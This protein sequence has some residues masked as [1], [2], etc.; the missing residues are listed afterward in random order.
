MTGLA[1]ALALGLTVLATIAT[2]LCGD[3]LVN[4]LPDVGVALADHNQG[5]G[6]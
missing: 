3:Q 6:G 5:S 4:I 1:L 2:P